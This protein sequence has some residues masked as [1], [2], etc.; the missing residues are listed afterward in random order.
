MAS[1]QGRARGGVRNLSDMAKSSQHSQEDSSGELSPGG[2]G[3]AIVKLCE[4]THRGLVFWSRQRF[5]VGA[6][7]QVRLRVEALPAALRELGVQGGGW[8][9]LRGFVVLCQPERK[10]NGAFGF[11]VSLLLVK[12]D[13][14]WEREKGA[15]TRPLAATQEAFRRHGWLGGHSL[16]L[17]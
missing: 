2:A 3:Q 17:N 14:G 7:L 10:G 8:M 9:N 16:G 5:E 1:F 13:G 11:E 4:A 12:A 6:E 15:W